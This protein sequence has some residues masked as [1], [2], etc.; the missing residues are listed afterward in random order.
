MLLRL[1]VAQALVIATTACLTISECVS[2]DKIHTE[3]PDASAVRY[4]FDNDSAPDSVL[5]DHFLTSLYLASATE[6]RARSR[7]LA[8]G[9]TDGSDAD[10]LFDYFIRTFLAIQQEIK[11]TKREVL[12]CDEEPPNALAELLP[13]YLNALDDIELLIL[14][15]YLILSETKLT[16][17][18]S[19][20]LISAIR[21]SPSSFMKSYVDH[22][23]VL[24]G[25]EPMFDSALR[26]VCM[27]TLRP[28]DHDVVNS[29]AFVSPIEGR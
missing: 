26:E 5:F 29:G 18:G 21:N 7:Y 4:L 28:Y 16:G 14:Q 15:K 24:S 9:M 20:D 1:P 2:A 10:E 6:D 17:L 3:L 8:P 11:K 13:N 23:V 22:R 25:N 12:L 19:Y 27:E